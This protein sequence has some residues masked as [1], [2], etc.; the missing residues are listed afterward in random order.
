[1]ANRS[2][3]LLKHVLKQYSRCENVRIWPN[4]KTLKSIIV[5]MD[6]STATKRPEQ[7][8]IRALSALPIE[9]R[10]SKSSQSAD[11]TPVTDISDNDEDPNC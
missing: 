10:E 9:M 6:V 11:D 3:E 7:V 1:M 8:I 2:P 4:V 5:P